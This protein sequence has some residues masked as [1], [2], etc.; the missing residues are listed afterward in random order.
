V[1]S[2]SLHP[3][4]RKRSS[5]WRNNL[6]CEQWWK[7]DWRYKEGKEAAILDQLYYSRASF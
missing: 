4:C 6:S 5:G 1:E 7:L 3:Y 2:H